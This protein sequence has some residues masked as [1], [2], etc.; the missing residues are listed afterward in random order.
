MEE[1]RQL[2]SNT[3]EPDD[4]LGVE[5]SGSQITPGDSD[6]HRRDVVVHGEFGKLLWKEMGFYGQPDTN[7]RVEVHLVQRKNRCS[8]DPNKGR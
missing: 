3:A 6:A 7:K 5:L 8:E 1:W 4:G 2:Q